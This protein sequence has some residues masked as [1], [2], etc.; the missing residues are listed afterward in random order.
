[1]KKLFS[2]N[3]SRYSDSYDYD[4]FFPSTLINTKDYAVSFITEEHIDQYSSFEKCSCN[5]IF[6]PEKYD[7]PEKICNR[8]HVFVL[9]KNPHLRFCQFFEENGIQS[10]PFK[11]KF[12]VID[13]AYI[14]E[15]AI[16]GENTEVFPG[17]YIGNEVCIGNNCY[18]APGVKLVG[19]V[20]VGNHVI[21]RENAVIGADGLTTDKN[22]EGI[23]VKM[24][25]FGGVW[26]GNNVT[27]G[28]NSVIARGAIDDTVI[29]HYA[30]IDNCVFIS[31]NVYVGQRTFIVGETIMFGSSSL[32]SG[33]FVSGNSTIRNGVRIGENTL[34]GMGSVVVKDVASNMT[35]KGNPAK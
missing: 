30:S 20:T 14:A 7:I 12:H 15:N 2:V 16:I 21:I 4:V 23:P 6:W 24:P 31:H 22:E 34:I 27:I 19:K 32:G 33:S 13:G 1:M 9:S 28:A 26:I 29:D 11:A 18:I 25:Q 17:A 3:V 10:L 5:L 35:V 8:N